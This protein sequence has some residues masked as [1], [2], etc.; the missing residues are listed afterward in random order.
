MI[1]LLHV[2]GDGLQVE[3]GQCPRIGR[4]PNQYTHPLA[5]L[6]QQADNIVP[7]QTSRPGNER[8]HDRFVSTRVVFS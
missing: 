5:A 6:Q 7:N 3:P 2:A 8:Q 4:R 1:R